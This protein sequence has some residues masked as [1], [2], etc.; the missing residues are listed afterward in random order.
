[1][2]NSLASSAGVTPQSFRAQPQEY[3][4]GGV[5]DALTG[6]VVKQSMQS[7]VYDALEGQPDNFIL[8]PLPYG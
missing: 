2:P 3:T 7:A 4:A 5:V 8:D 6:G 1:M